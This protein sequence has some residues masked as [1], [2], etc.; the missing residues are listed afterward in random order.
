M[1]G[2]THKQA[3]KYLRLD[4]DGL[5]TDDQRLDLETHLSGC[6]SC[7]VETQAFTTLTSRLQS[8]FRSRWDA[9]DGPSKNVM[10]NVRSQ[11]RR[12]IMSNRINFGIRALAGVAA[13]L[14][15]GFLINLVVSQMRDNSIAA[16]VTVT[17]DTLMPV[18]AQA[19]KRLLAFTKETDGNFDIYTIRA[20][21][22]ELTNLTNDPA[23][24]ANPIW[25]PDGKHIAF[26]SDR[27][28][29]MQIYLMDADG[30]NVIQITNDEADHSLPMNMDGITS[31]WSPDGSKILFLQNNPGDETWTLISQTINEEN[32][33]S[34]GTGRFF[35]NGI[36]W[37]PD[38]NYIG[39]VLNDVSDA[40][41]YV[42][43]IY[44]ID[45]DGGNPRE[46][47]K[48]VPP[49]ENLD[50]RYHWSLN[51]GSVIITTTQNG[52]LRQTVYQFN[53]EN[54]T[55]LQK[56]I[57]NAEVLDWGDEISLV[58]NVEKP[59]LSLAWQR[60]D[61]TGN[62]FD[63]G[64]N[65]LFI[66]F[67]RSPLGNFAVGAYCDDG[68]FRL[69]W[70]NPDGSTV[71]QLL[72]F[73]TDTVEGNGDISWSPDDRYIAFNIVSS[74]ETKMYILN[75]EIA[76]EDPSV[77][78]EQVLVGG[79]E[80]YFI[81]SWQPVLTE[82]VVE[83][84]PTPEPTQTSPNTGL[85]AFT[86]AVEN[87][88]LDIYTM[89]PDGGALTNLTNNPAH[90]INPYW[91]PDGS[92]IAFMSDRAGFMHLFIMNADGSDVTQVT[93]DQADHEFG[94][95]NHSPWSPDGNR[96]LFT[97]RAL[98]EEKWTLGAVDVDGQ[99]KTPLSLVPTIYNGFSWSPDGQHVAFIVIKQQNGP[100]EREVGRIHVVDTNGG[101]LTDATNLV[102]TDEDLWNWSYSWS[103]DGQTIFFIADRYYYENGNGKSTLYE[104]S[105]DGN[106]LIEIDHVSTH[107]ADWWKGTSFIDAPASMQPLTWLRPDG[108][109]STLNAF[110]NCE[111]S[112]SQHGLNYKRSSNGD[113]IIGAGCA[114]DD[115]WFHW[116]N[117]DGTAIQQLLN[118]PIHVAQGSVGFFWSPDDKYV[119]LQ[120]SSSDIS[121]LYL[122]NVAD[123]LNDPSF[124]LVQVPLAGGAQY[125]NISWQPLP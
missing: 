26:E 2:I 25:S 41:S 9:Q 51:E 76:L 120:A 100:Q 78:P 102:P 104:A 23:R 83:Q 22:S 105:L 103:P 6:E 121:Y 54:G 3:Q 94:G 32:R 86:S 92:R 63:T 109:H 24:D 122:V 33:V 45:A 67:R 80:Q 111:A 58:L 28:G 42:P 87:G 72:D 95:S 89:Q 108:T 82:E 53:V 12:I 85:I 74:D 81:S 52:P 79:G 40:N 115:W 34:L 10:A 5:L 118:Y 38:G 60:P 21:G 96:L 123:A 11:T 56:S 77:Q 119:A 84:K 64:V 29:I 49:D 117:P 14:L 48:L 70:A 55:L 31:P 66:N 59:E 114:N 8:G 1:N 37:S 13:V 90:D 107:M 35:L 99:N 101:N 36:S 30:S 116:A 88:N 17:P 20:D 125:Y 43:V 57:L 62:T 18:S 50:S 39:Y 15:F 106:S 124:Q 27:T 91:S 112:D 98:G 113:L 4:L 69:Y 110:K 93:N 19:E 68:Q 7:R 16:K 73:R 61:G 47:K 65:A 71:K 75:V 46:L 44:I 97:E